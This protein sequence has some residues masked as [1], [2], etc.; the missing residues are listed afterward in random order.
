M[1]ITA[2]DQSATDDTAGSRDERWSSARGAIT[3]ILIALLLV[4]VFVGTV[5]GFVAPWP[6]SVSGLDEVAPALVGAGFAWI[7]LPLVAGLWLRRWWWGAL[8]FATVLAAAF[9]WQ[10]GH[11]V[12]TSYFGHRLLVPNDPIA[13]WVVPT[14]VELGLLAAA[15]GTA[16][17]AWGRHGFPGGIEN[18]KEWTALCLVVA[19]VSVGVGLT[20]GF[21][22]I[23]TTPEIFSYL[24]LLAAA[25]LG[26]F[27]AGYWLRQWWWPAVCLVGIGVMAFWGG[28]SISARDPGMAS[29]D[30][31]SSSP[32]ARWR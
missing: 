20:L 10:G 28:S 11:P 19:P 13:V 26:A 29:A 5:T 3:A 6:W 9:A 16:G 23:D 8:C 18:L 4:P 14:A 22:P 7:A 15:A 25:T 21:E 2:H 1:M 32:E 27:A 30:L 17:V 12:F 24:I 31:A